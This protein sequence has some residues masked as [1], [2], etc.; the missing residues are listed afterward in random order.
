MTSKVEAHKLFQNFVAFQSANH[1]AGRIVAGDIRRIAGNNIADE[2]SNRVIAL[3]LQGVV[4]IQQDVLRFIAGFLN[5]VQLD[6]QRS[7]LPAA[8]YHRADDVPSHFIIY[9]TQQSAE[10]KVLFLCF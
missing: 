10:R 7:L 6:S 4:D 3:G 5:G 9:Y 8:A 1:A 2:L